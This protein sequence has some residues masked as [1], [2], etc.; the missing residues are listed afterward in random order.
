MDQHKRI[1]VDID[2]PRF[3]GDLLGD[4]VGVIDSRQPGPDIQELA[5]PRVGSQV[6]H[7]AHEK[8]AGGA[9]DIDDLG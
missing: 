3:G 7:D 8:L 2:N 9:G 6:P 5:D 4:L 1:V